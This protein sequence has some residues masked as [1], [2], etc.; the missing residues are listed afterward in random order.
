MDP[1]SFSVSI[2]SAIAAIV[3]VVFA[4]RAVK[5]AEK[6]NSIGLFTELH[7]IYH[8]NETYEAIRTIW[9]LY[10]R[11]QKQGGDTPITNEQAI[12]FVTKADKK[13]PEWK[14]I[15][16]ISLFWRYLALLLKKGLIEQVQDLRS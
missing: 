7:R 6:T 1:I 16:D 12:D 11:Y 10:N 9:E 15:H 13:S 4:W 8:S 5:T 14:A 2:L 3:S